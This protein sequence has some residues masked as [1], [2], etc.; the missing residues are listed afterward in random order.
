MGDITNFRPARYPRDLRSIL[1][2]GSPRM[3]M[4]QC[5][6]GTDARVLEKQIPHARQVRRIDSYSV[7]VNTII[8]CAS[9]NLQREFGFRLPAKQVVTVHPIFDSSIRVRWRPL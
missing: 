2:H 9:K 5:D 1:T 6:H 7:A 4:K 8:V 3:G